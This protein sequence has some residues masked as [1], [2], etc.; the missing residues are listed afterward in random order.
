MENFIIALIVFFDYN[1]DNIFNWTDT[2]VQS[3]T[4][5]PS[6]YC[7]K[8]WDVDYTPC[9]YSNIDWSNIPNTSPLQWLEDP[10][11]FNEE[12]FKKWFEPWKRLYLEVFDN[13]QIIFHT[14]EE[15]FRWNWTIYTISTNDNFLLDSYI[16]KLLFIVPL[17]LMIFVAWFVLFPKKK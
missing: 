3:N 10:V 15:N 8:E 17:L 12:I 11:F 9:W 1:N 4:A 14:S 7:L 13:K 16:K 2:L 6:V 5:N